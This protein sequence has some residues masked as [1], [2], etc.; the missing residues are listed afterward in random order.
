M[1]PYC[2]ESS[3]IIYIYPEDT[4]LTAEVFVKTLLAHL[5]SQLQ[6]SLCP[7][8]IWGGHVKEAHT[9]GCKWRCVEQVRTTTGPHTP[10]SCRFPLGVGLSW[11]G[12]P[13]AWLPEECH[14]EQGISPRN[15]LRNDP[16]LRF[17]TRTCLC[18]LPYSLLRRGNS[19]TY[20]VAHGSPKF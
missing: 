9:G 8:G 16:G 7:P 2:R 14:G 19:G 6:M 20:C 12:A 13:P 15:R 3:S 4:E 1:T 10:A 5:G 17:G 18:T 11:Q